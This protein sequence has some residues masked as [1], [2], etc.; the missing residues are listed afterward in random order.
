MAFSFLVT[1]RERE[2]ASLRSSVFEICPMCGIMSV[3][4][5]LSVNAEMQSAVIYSK[6]VAVLSRNQLT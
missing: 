4:Y 2:N 5:V 6:N 3:G 1:L